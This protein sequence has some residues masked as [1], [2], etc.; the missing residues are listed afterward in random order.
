MSNQRALKTI[1]CVEEQKEALCLWHCG[2]NTKEIGSLIDA[3]EYAVYNGL[4]EIREGLRE[5]RRIASKH[6][7]RLVSA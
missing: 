1:L 7:L 3:E 4:Y 2:F 6:S 5:V